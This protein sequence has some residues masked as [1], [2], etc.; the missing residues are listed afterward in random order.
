M[1][2]KRFSKKQMQSLC[3]EIHSDD[4]VDP[5]EFFRPTRKSNSNHRKAQQLCH[6]YRSCNANLR[7]QLMRIIKRAGLKPWGKPF[8]N[9]RSTRETELMETFPAHVVCGWIGNSEA[10]ALKH[11]LQVTDDHFERAVRGEAEANGE[12]RATENGAQKEAQHAHAGSRRE[13]HAVSHANAKAPVLPG[14]ATS[15]V[16]H[17]EWNSRKNPRENAGLRGCA[18]RKTTQLP[19]TATSTPV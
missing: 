3:G 18:T 17:G 2:R 14:L 9:L 15:C 16:P 7:T 10:I 12:A 1:N 13:Q 11:Y 5:T 6:T 19:K 4:G 8:P